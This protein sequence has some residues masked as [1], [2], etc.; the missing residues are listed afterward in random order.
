M[1]PVPASLG[2]RPASHGPVPAAQ[3]RRPLALLRGR[4]WLLVLTAWPGVGAVAFVLVM[5]TQAGAAALLIPPV[6]RVAS[7]VGACCALAPTTRAWVAARRATV[8]G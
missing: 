1:A 3:D 6:L 5:A 2:P 8:V 4:G 7:V